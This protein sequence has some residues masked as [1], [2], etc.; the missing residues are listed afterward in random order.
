MNKNVN[1][2]IA[3]IISMFMI[4]SCHFCNEMG[5]KIG[6][7]L[8]QTFNVGVFIFIRLPIWEKGRG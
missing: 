3:R 5:N 1:I 8:G 7:V 2:S 4:L 6:N